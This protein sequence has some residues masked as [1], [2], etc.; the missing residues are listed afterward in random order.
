MNERMLHY[1]LDDVTDAERDALA[2]EVATDPSAADAFAG[3]FR[4]E[5]RLEECVREQPASEDGIARV[6]QA[7]SRDRWSPRRSWRR[8]S[9]LRSSGR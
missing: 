2:T 9:S 4:M 8:R 5:S 1:L 3:M 6:G 7:E